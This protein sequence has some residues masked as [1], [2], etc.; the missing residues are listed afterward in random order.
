M[1]RQ[2]TSTIILHCLC[3]T[4]TQWH[5]HSCS[6]TNTTISI[7]RTRIIQSDSSLPQYLDREDSSVQKFTFYVQPSVNQ[8]HNQYSPTLRLRHTSAMPFVYIFLRRSF[9]FKKWSK[10]LIPSVNKSNSK[11]FQKAPDLHREDESYRGPLLCLSSNKCGKTGCQLSSEEEEVAGRGGEGRSG[12]EGGRG[13][14]RSGEH[15][16]V[17]L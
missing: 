12:W 17:V 9:F 5:S 7:I 11:Q 2:S 13:G 4:K 8:V 14:S 6:R 10:Y 15:G 3:K 1:W 16:H